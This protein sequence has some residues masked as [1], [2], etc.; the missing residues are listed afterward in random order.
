[1]QNIVDP[2]KRKHIIQMNSQ[3]PKLK[4]KIKIHKPDAPIRPVIN[5]IYA[6]THKLAK[7]I[8]QKLHDLLNLKYEYNIINTIHLMDNIKK[9]KLKPDQKILTLCGPAI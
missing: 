5:S 6:P 7:S 2:T 1:M 3:A 4:A 8:H 9:L